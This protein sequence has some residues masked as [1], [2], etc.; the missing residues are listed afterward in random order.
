ME[1]LNESGSISGHASLVSDLDV[2]SDFA[3]ARR[4]H[5]ESEE[6]VTYHGYGCVNL[7]YT[8]AASHFVAFCTRRMSKKFVCLL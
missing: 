7:F 4:L 2:T 8:Y 1:H 6:V 5:E 3:W